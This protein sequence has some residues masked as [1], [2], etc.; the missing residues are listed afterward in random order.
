MSLYKRKDSPNYWIKL[1]VNGRRIQKGT[2]TADKKKAQEYHDK[3]K[4]RLWDETR[5]GAKPVYNWNDAV[6]RWLKE[7]EHKATRADDLSNLR[8][9][10]QFLNGKNLTDINRELLKRIGVRV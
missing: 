9:L 3:L 7:T 5:L 6:V 2:G 8:W 4:A 1:T 10:D